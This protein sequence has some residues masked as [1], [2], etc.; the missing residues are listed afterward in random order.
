MNL[1]IIFDF[2]PWPICFDNWLSRGKKQYWP[3]AFEASLVAQTVK[4]LPAMWRTGCDP[5]VRKIPWRMAWHPTPVFLPGEAP[6]TEEPGRLQ[7]MGRKESNT[8]EWLS[9]A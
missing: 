9:V 3:I 7:S 2:D 1:D 8:T 6:R 4:N 5:W